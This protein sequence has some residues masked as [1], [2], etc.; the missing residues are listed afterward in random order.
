M[1]R[2]LLIFVFFPFAAPAKQFD[3]LDINISPVLKATYSVSPEGD[4]HLRDKLPQTEVLKNDWH[5][6][7]YGTFGPCP[8]TYPKVIADN[9]SLNWYRER[10]LKA[11]KKYVGLPYRHFHFPELGG[12][13]CSNFT[14]WIY[15]YA[16]G[17]RFSSNVVRQ[18]LKAGRRLSRG[19]E[20]SPGDLI[21]LADPKRHVIVHV[22]IY[23]NK[24]SVIDS[25]GTSVQIRPFAGRY[26]TDLA[27]ARRII[28]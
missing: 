21:F 17:I 18:S 1:N 19:E 26:K 15:N 13:D 3:C 25:S 9:K 6:K 24:S 12:L 27:W 11:A 8:M 10:V 4:F 16:F 5:N 28:K 7:K 23:M 20:L 2:T 14:S 22:A